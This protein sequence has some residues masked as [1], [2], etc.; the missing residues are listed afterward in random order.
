MVIERAAA[1]AKH[2]EIE[3]AV[4]EALNPKR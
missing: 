3:L 1:R 4:F 2:A